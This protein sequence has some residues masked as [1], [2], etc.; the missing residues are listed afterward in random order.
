MATLRDAIPTTRTSRWQL[1]IDW[2]RT[3]IYAILILGAFASVLPFLYMIMT[4]LI[5]RDK[6]RSTQIGR[7]KLSL[8]G[9]S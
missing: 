7:V 3:L 5:Q 2:T 4:S 6:M 9:D 1:R 8:P